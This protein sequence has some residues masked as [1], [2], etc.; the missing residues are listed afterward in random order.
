[1]PIF[2]VRNKKAEE[3]EKKLVGV[4]LPKQISS[5]LALYALSKGVT[6]SLVLRKEMEEWHKKE[7]ILESERNLIEGLIQKVKH[8]WEKDKSSYPTNALKVFWGNQLEDELEGKGI[9]EENISQ[10]LKIF[11]RSE[12]NDE[13]SIA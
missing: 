11:R 12:K 1:M 13:T 6:K 5:Y 3:S 7:I 4:F 8:Q 10:I 9:S 2:K